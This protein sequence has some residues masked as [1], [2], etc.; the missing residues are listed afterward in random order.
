WENHAEYQLFWIFDAVLAREPIDQQLVFKWLDVHPLLVF[1]ILKKFVPDETGLFAEPW[2]EHGPSVVQQIVRAAHVVPVASL[3]A[4]EKLRGTIASIDFAVYLELLELLTLAVRAPQQVQETLFVLHECREDVRAGSPASEYAHKQA[5][6]VTL[7]RA[8]E[9][10]DEC[11]CDDDG[12]IRK[13]RTAPAVVPLFAV[14]GD[15]SA[16]IAHVRVDSPNP[17]RL[18]SHVRFRAASKPEKGDVESVILDGVVT[19]AQSGE[20]KV[21]LVHSPP[22]EFARMQW[23]LYDVGSVATFRA[24]TQ[25]IRRLASDGAESCRFHR[26]ITDA[27]SWTEQEHDL[28]VVEDVPEEVEREA[29]LNDSQQEAV[30]RSQTARV[31]LIWGPPGTGKTTVVVQIL[32]RLIKNLKEGSKILMTASTNNGEYPCEHAYHTKICIFSRGQCPGTIRPP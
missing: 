2:R 16:V 6:A 27:E 4:L 3:V 25:A 24:M 19:S 21:S 12:R 9:A 23:Y 22:P 15:P 7:D 20:I 26:M 18:H 14:E 30:R 5:L 11:P 29:S 17:T 1:C 8:Q 13:Q 10:A 31:S 28:H 32:K